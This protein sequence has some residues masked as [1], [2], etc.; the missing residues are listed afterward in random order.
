MCRMM[1]MHH[2]DVYASYGLAS[3]RTSTC[4]TPQRYLEDV[5]RHDGL[6]ARYTMKY[7]TPGAPTP[8]TATGI[9]ETFRLHR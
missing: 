2:I 6:P 7:C 8:A 9:N 1:C 5:G 3:H 4:L